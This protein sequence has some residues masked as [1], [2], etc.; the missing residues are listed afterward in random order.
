MIDQV[1]WGDG[2]ITKLD[3][4]DDDDDDDNNNNNTQYLKVLSMGQVLLVFHSF[5]FFLV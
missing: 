4:D 3:D 5:F 2:K 1:V